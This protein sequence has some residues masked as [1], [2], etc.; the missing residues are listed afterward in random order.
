[1][2]S[3]LLIKSVFFRR[4][5][6]VANTNTNSTATAISLER[7]ERVWVVA[8]ALVS[9]LWNSYFCNCSNFFCFCSSFFLITF[10]FQ[11]FLKLLG[12]WGCLPVRAKPHEPVYAY[13]LYVRTKYQ[14]VYNEISTSSFLL[15]TKYQPAH[16]SSEKNIFLYR[17]G[18][19]TMYFFII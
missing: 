11:N 12:E 4:K 15:R 17:G 16:F 19:T 7:I 18:K 5:S 10:L 2:F 13:M 1:M 3:W 9:K 6:I 8:L 14:P